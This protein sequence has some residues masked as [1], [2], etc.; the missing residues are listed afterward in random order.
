MKMYS[1]FPKENVFR[2]QKFISKEMNLLLLQKKMN[3]KIEYIQGTKVFL[4]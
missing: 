3:S 2:V 1:I 4:K